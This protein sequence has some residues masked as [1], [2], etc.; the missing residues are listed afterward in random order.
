MRTTAVKTTTAQLIYRDA[1]Q[2]MVPIHFETIG[3]KITPARP[4]PIAVAES[5]V[6]VEWAN[7]LLKMIEQDAPE[8]NQREMP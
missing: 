2:P 7:H 3:L 6:P 8:Q 4:E 5:R 1:V